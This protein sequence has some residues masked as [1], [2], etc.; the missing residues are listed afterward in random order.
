[1]TGFNGAETNCRIADSLGILLMS[2]NCFAVY[3]Q[4]HSS[5]VAFSFYLTPS[6]PTL[7]QA[8]PSYLI[9]C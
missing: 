6:Y 4:Q 5:Y 1:M 9:L 2:S 7:F 8:L 3:F